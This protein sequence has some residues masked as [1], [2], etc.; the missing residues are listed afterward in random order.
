[1]RAK[2]I[3]Y[4][5]LKINDNKKGRLPFFYYLLKSDI[6]K[7]TKTISCDSISKYLKYWS[8]FYDG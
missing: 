8:N 1:M 6:A 7:T 5:L 3:K 4:L 2:T